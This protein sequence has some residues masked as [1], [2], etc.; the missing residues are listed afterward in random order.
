MERSLISEQ[1]R[2][3]AWM[4]YP[5]ALA[6]VAFSLLGSCP[7]MFAQCNSLK[8]RDTLWVRLLQPLS[9]YSGKAG[10]KI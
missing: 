2:R 4:Q 9:S 10:D 3:Y 8:A 5:R 1:P 6:L 7:A